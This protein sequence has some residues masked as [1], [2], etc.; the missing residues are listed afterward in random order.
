MKIIKNFFE[1]SCVFLVDKFIDERGEFLE[2]FNE[3]IIKKK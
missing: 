3:K 2:I 1:T